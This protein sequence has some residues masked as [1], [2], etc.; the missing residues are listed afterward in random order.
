MLSNHL[1]L[2][3]P[4]LLLP[5]IFPSIWVFSNE[6]VLRIRWPTYWSFSFSISLCNEYL[7]QISFRI[8]W[9]VYGDFLARCKSWLPGCLLRHHLLLEVGLPSGG[10]SPNALLAMVGMGKGGDICFS[11]V[12]GWR[13]SVLVKKCFV[14]P[15]CSFPSPLT[16][17]SGVFSAVCLCVFGISG[18]LASPAPMLG[19]LSQEEPHAHT[20][21]SLGLRLVSSQASFH[22]PQSSVV[23]HV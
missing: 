17:D 7:E 10:Q 19:Y 3:R 22:L 20:M 6:S 1:I 15:G 14:F 13:T 5:S 4:L 9:H 21:F 2:C 11:V 8:D 23:L 18:L 12:W 16:G